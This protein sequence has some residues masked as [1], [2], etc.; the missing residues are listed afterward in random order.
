ML[1]SK[2]KIKITGKELK[3]YIQIHPLMETWYMT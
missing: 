1:L 3:G 2:Y